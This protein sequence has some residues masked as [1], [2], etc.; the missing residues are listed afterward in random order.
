MW[1]PCVPLETAE[2]VG[3]II[4]NSH[5][6]NSLVEIMLSILSEEH[7]GLRGQGKTSF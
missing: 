2:L 5:L 6:W 3:G 7:L 4:L 1:L